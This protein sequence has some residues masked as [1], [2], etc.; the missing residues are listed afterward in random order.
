MERNTKEWKARRFVNSSKLK[1]KS[2]PEEELTLAYF[3][4]QFRHYST[5][6]DIIGAMAQ[7]QDSVQD[8]VAKLIAHGGKINSYYLSGDIRNKQALVYLK[9]WFSGHNVREAITKAFAKK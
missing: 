1:E 5:I 9:G 4:S 3:L 2:F 7:I 6:C 8:L